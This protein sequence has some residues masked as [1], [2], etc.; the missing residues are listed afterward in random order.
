MPV[1]A[2]LRLGGERIDVVPEDVEQPSYAIFAE[3]YT[4]ST[5]S[6]WPVTPDDTCSYVG[7][8]VCPPV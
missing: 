1:V 3:S 7:F 5:D 4:I 8:F 6:A 2:E